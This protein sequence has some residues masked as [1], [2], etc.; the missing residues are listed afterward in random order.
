MC[1][2]LLILVIP[3]YRE[4][5]RIKIYHRYEHSVLENFMLHFIKNFLFALLDA[6]KNGILRHHLIKIKLIAQAL[7]FLFTGAVQVVY[8]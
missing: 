8:A 1:I 3:T 5:C 4:N 6:Q 7:T 2:L